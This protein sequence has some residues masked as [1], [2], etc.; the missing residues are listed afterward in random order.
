MQQEEQ[1]NV[2]EVNKMDETEWLPVVEFDGVEYV[3]D[4]AGGRRFRSC[5]DPDD[6]I[7]FYSEKGRQMVEA[8]VGTEWRAWMPR[9]VV[10]RE[11]VV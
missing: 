9:E 3:V 6:S 11:L 7:G 1:P 10:E 2:A 4:V 5:I 8:M